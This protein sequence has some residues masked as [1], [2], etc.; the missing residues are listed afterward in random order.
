VSV[1]PDLVVLEVLERGGV[2]PC[3][4]VLEW[5]AEFRYCLRAVQPVVVSLDPSM[6]LRARALLQGFM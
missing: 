3:D 5:Y 2:K 4:F 6:W 1:V